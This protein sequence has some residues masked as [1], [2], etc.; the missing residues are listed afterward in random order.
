MGTLNS[1]ESIQN[2]IADLENARKEPQSTELDSITMSQSLLRF[3]PYTS[4]RLTELPQLKQ[5]SSKNQRQI[6]KNTAS[7]KPSETNNKSTHS[8][9]SDMNTERT[10]IN[11]FRE[12]FQ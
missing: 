3:K 2:L 11:V 4:K 12:F 6:S 1:Q 5:Y 10:N 8:N 9:T 7:N